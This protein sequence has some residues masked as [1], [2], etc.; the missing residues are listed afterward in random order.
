MSTDK[1]DWMIGQP[2]PLLEAH[3]A[4]KHDVFRSY[5]GRYIEVLTSNPR[6]DALGLTLIDGF[7]GGGEYKFRDTIVPGS[8]MILLQEVACAQARLTIQ[9]RK[10]FRLNAEF[11]FVERSTAN[12][13]FLEY[14]IRQSEYRS[15][16]G[17]SVHLLNAE[18]EQALPQILTRIRARTRAHR[19]IFFLDQYGYSQ[20]S[21][22]TIRT[23]LASLNNPEII[24][25]FNVDWLIS[26]LNADDGFLKAVKPV[27]LD[28]NAIKRM[29]ALMKEPREG[30]WLVQNLLF[31]HL[32]DKTGAPYYTCFFI[33]SP[34]SNL[35]YWLVHISKHPKARDEM[36]RLHW[37]MT[38]HF[39]HHG[40]AGLKMLGF[41]PEQDTQQI[42]MD[43]LFDDNA[44]ARTTN[45]L[46]NE[47][48][49]LIFDRSAQNSA[50]PT[51]ENLFT[52]V[53]NE[54][55][56]TMKQIAQVLVGLRNEREI[57]IFTKDGGAKPRSE[58]IAWTDVIL[59]ARQRSLL[60][61]VWP[62]T[63]T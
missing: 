45:A 60:S 1:Y 8:P 15:L 46:M 61:T 41:D 21:L 10:P 47:L 32:R 55:P 23:I 44:E 48:P 31:Q 63:R 6:R 42:P 49:P 43:F 16:L 54:T 50:P 56:A 22:E 34:T 12:K 19:S 53:C 7:A 39:A 30:R 9:R 51:L 2:P 17:N 57:E 36:A 59:P 62:P 3:S 33:K 35:S 18:F 28:L 58:Q 26:F 40:R 38:N 4:A 52:H 24:L 13:E 5:I 20:V 25:T 37:V 14:T 11:I 29:L 27:E